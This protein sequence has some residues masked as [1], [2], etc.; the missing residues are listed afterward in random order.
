MACEC[1]GGWGDY[2][3]FV[4]GGYNFCRGAANVTIQHD[5]AAK[6]GLFGFHPGGKGIGSDKVRIE[7]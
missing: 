7:S 2:L 4:A 6:D 1:G 5:L 3:H